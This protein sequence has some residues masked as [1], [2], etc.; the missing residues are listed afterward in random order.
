MEKTYGPD[1][2]KYVSGK[3]GVTDLSRFNNSWYQPGPRWKVLLW[4][5]V[6]TLVLKNYLPIPVL[7]KIKV[8]QLFGA[9]IGHHVMIKPNVN[10]KYPWFLEIGNYVWIGEGVWIDNFS[11]VIIKDNAC[12]S[13]GAM[14][15]TGNHNYQL[16]TFDLMPKP[17]TIEEGAWVGARTVVCPGV[18]CKSHSV[19]AVGSVATRS[20]EP[21][22]VYQGNPANF[23]RK[24]EIKA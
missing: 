8:M 16:P 10:V 24:R 1:Q 7:I 4:F 2:D 12:L 17:I 14:L 11:M 20:L 18:V 13:Q 21:Y 9:K 3:Q 15:L 22:G 6:N 19:L 5:F 23:V